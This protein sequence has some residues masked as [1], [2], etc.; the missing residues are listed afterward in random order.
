MKT[1]LAA[2][3]ATA[4]FATSYEL[5]ETVKTAPAHGVAVGA[6]QTHTSKGLG[7]TPGSRDELAGSR[8]ETDFEFR[9]EHLYPQAEQRDLSPH[10][11]RSVTRHRRPAPDR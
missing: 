5:A 4:A 3:I 7:S 6:A 9:P 11:E 1:L 2:T 10:P 8:E